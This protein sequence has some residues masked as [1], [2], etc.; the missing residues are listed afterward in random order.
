M[1]PQRAA[2]RKSYRIVDVLLAI[3]VAAGVFSLLWGYGIAY[4]IGY[5]A[6]ADHFGE[7]RHG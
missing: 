3:A 6:A 1:P 2:H 7:V 5:D 4:Q